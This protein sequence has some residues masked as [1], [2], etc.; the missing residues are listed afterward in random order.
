LTIECDVLVVGAGPAG[1]SAAFFLKHL[2]RHNRLEVKLIERLN[3]KKYYLFHDMCGEG[4]SEDLYTDISPIKPNYI[5]EKIRLL[6]EYWPGNIEVKTPLKGYIIDRPKFFQNIIKNFLDF[7]GKFEH[8]SVMDFVV[9]DDNVKVKLNDGNFIKTKY[10]IAA[11]GSNSIFRKKMGIP[12][13]IKT[14]IQY[15]V[16]VEPDHGTLIFQYD[17][18]WEGDYKWIFP[19]GNNTKIGFPNVIN[20]DKIKEIILKKQSRQVGFG[21]IKDYVHRNILLV[22]DAACQNNPI[23]KGGIR[24]AMKAG[25]MAAQAVINDD[26]LEYDRQWKKSNFASPIFNIAFD[27][28]KN[29]NNKELAKHMEP[30]KNGVNVLSNIKSLIFYRKYLDLYRAYNLSNRVGW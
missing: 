29:M 27:R 17:E 12:G 5:D 24:P 3:E 15:I 10:L 28:L 26:P 18:K 4:V 2:D 7:G 20:K 30:F 6:K 9:A 21:G 25:K 16:D 13:R 22:G 1:V 23:T 8:S 11:D 19:H 14:L